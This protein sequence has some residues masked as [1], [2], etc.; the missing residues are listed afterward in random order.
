[1]RL[2]FDASAILNLNHDGKTEQ[3]IDHATILLAQYE[4]GN[5]VWKKVSQTHEMT[6]DA[7]KQYLAKTLETLRFMTE[8][9]IVDASSVLEI[10]ARERISYYDASYIHTAR[11]SASI[12]ITDDAKLRK[13]AVKYVKTNDSQHVS[14]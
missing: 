11:V 2:L 10:A 9:D 5:A 6:E 3:Y 8:I 1:M 4:I 14:E 13:A 7:G 12:L